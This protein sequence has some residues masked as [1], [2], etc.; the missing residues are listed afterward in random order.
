MMAKQNTRNIGYSE[1]VTTRITAEI[2]SEKQH[3]WHCDL[4]T[5]L[6]LLAGGNSTCPYGADTIYS[7][8]V[9]GSWLWLPPTYV[10]N[11]HY[12]KYQDGWQNWVKLHMYVEQNMKSLALY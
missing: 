2:V 1:E 12:L 11:S 4:H 10:H 7:G 3:K 6:Q 5:Y 8:V 9:A